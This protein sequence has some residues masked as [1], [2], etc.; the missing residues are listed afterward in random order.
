MSCRK[1]QFSTLAAGFLFL[2]LDRNVVV[3]IALIRRTEHTYCI[4]PET[5]GIVMMTWIRG[6]GRLM[7]LIYCIMYISSSLL[8]ISRVLER[9][10]G[11]Y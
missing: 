7:K 4:G 11:Y 6:D 5:V 10:C 2:L 3:N 9:A 1:W 8:G